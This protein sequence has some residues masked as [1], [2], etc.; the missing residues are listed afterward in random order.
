MVYLLL[1]LTVVALAYV[2]FRALRAQA[3]KPPTRVIGPDDEDWD[4]AFVARYPS[5]RAFVEMLRDPDYQ[6]AVRH[7]NAATADSRLIC[8]A[9]QTPG[10]TFLAGS[11]A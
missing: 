11:P 5:A 1:I 10:A 9:V 2:G 8:C 4:L 3:N 7:R 6:R